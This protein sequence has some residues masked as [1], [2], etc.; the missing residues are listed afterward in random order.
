MPR[1]SQNACRYT[2]ISC[3][4]LSGAQDSPGHTIAAKQMTGGFGGMLSIRVKGGEQA[5]IGVA[6]KV[7][8]W[9]RADVARRCRKPDRTPR[10]GR[11]PGLPMPGGFAA[12]V[13]RHRGCG[14]SGEGFGGGAEVGARLIQSRHGRP[15]GGRPAGARPRV[16]KSPLRPQDAVALGGRVKPV[17][18]ELDYARLAI[19][20]AAVV[21]RACR[22]GKG[23]S[24]HSRGSVSGPCRCCSP[25]APRR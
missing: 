13:R 1:R 8:I 20:A 21:C 2:P 15:R 12:P 17:H 10:L 19:A 5:A 9:K 7:R 3:R 6:A 22:G 14:G 25:P 18:D 11:R 24:W 4:C 16:E 23:A